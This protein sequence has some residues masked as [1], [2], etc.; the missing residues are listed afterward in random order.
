MRLS[1]ASTVHGAGTV[2]ER[3]KTPH[4]ATVQRGYIGP[5]QPCTATFANDKTKQAEPRG[6]RTTQL[7]VRLRH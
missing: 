5:A 2:Q 6:A 4:G 7:W 3:C 1:P